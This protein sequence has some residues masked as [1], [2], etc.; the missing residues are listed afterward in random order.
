[1]TNQ[2]IAEQARAALRRHVLEPLLPRCVDQEYGGFLVD[3][4]DQWRPAGPHGKT[5]EHASRMTLAFALVERAMPGEGYDRLV[6]H[7]CA[8]LQG[9][10][11]DAAHGGF[12][13]QVDRSGRP[14]WEGLKHP[15]AVTY[16]TQAFLLA[17]PCLPPGEG[18]LWARRALAWLDDVAWDPDHGGYWGSYHRDNQRYPDGARLPTPDG[19][20]VLGRTPGFKEINTVGDAIEML[21]LCV[22]Q[23]LGGC[24]TER[25]GWLIDLVVER[26][27]GPAGV[28]P[29]LYWPDWQPAP[30]LMRVGPQ[31][32][33]IHRLL[34]AAAVN[35]AMDP[36]ARCCQLADFCLGSARHPSGGFCFAVSGDGRSWPSSG[37]STELRQWWVQLEAVRALHA[38][39]THQGIDPSLRARYGQARDQQWAFLRDHFFDTRY[40]G[41]WELPVEPRTR[42]HGHL[43]RGLRPKPPGPRSLRKTHGWKDPLHEVGTFLALGQ[44]EL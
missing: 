18:H 20:D 8:F 9:A 42:W 2:E 43:P 41:I 21:T 7:G 25:L 26:L 34:D 5:L 4:D 23:G 39:A 16:A 24:C 15:H 1:V 19:R 32:Q 27:S 22:G 40:G 30:D 17:E 13:A 3:F 44:T 33:L 31:F 35:G 10:L 38:L 29:Y 37:P 11:W 6:R 14:C 28:I 36:V 12:F